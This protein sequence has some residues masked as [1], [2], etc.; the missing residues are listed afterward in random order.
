MA[1]HGELHNVDMFSRRLSCAGT[2]APPLTSLAEAQKF[3]GTSVLSG[4]GEI[5]IIILFCK[6]G[7]LLSPDG[8]FRV[9]ERIEPFDELRCEEG[10]DAAHVPACSITCLVPSFAELEK[11]R[12]L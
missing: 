9:I 6:R 10:V 7:V 5:I 3:S 2:E 11:Q 12:P 8:F 1:R 4:S